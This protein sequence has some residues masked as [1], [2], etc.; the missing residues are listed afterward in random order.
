MA[1]D[2]GSVIAK[3]KADLTEFKQGLNQ[4][5]DLGQT[6]ADKV[7]SGIDSMNG[8]IKN[9]TPT[10]LKAS[11]TLGVVGAAGTVMLKD[12]IDNANEAARTQ[13]Q[14][15][16][17]LKS[18]KGAAGLTADEVN[19]LASKYQSMTTIGDDAIRSG[20]NILLTFT[21]IKKDAFEP[22]TAALL[23]MATAMNGGATPSAEQ[24]KAQATQLGTALNDPVK[25]MAALSRNG[26]VFTDE[27]AALITKLQESGDLLG[28]QKI[29]L[30][31][32]AAEYGGSAAAQTLTFE[33][34][35]TQL[36][37]RF[38]DF[39]ETL[40]FAV[41]PAL[42]QLMAV[43]ERVMTW[44]ENLSPA[45]Q[46]LIAKGVLLGTAL[47]LIGAPLLLIVTMIPALI[48]GF[49]AIAG[50]IALLFSPITLVIAMFVA[51]G[52]IL[53]KY[54]D[55]FATFF[56]ILG[57]NIRAFLSFIVEL[58]TSDFMHIQTIVTTTFDF[59]TDFLSLF[60]DTVKMLFKLWFAV[61]TGDWKGAWDVIKN[62]AIGAFNVIQEWAGKFWEGLTFV[63]TQGAQLVSS[64]WSG[65][66]EG[67]KSIALTVWE[68]IKSAFKDGINWIIDK[69]N[70][71]IRSY[72]SVIS[73]VPGVGKKL[74]IPEIPRLAQ[75]GIVK[76][77]PGGIMAN[78]GEGRYDEA[79]VPLDGRTG[80][81]GTHFHFHDSIISSKE[82]A[83]EILDQAMRTIRPNL[84]I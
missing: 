9:M 50:G 61:F 8:S 11:A 49:T 73:K 58:W 63:F 5:K 79:V 4:A 47:A 52:I 80:M 20:Q 15:E 7:K 72:S 62:W 45:T 38:G 71:V 34:R 28:A 55:E 48:A 54:R 77:T 10:L 25:G 27:Q 24:L 32:L 42:E 64:A 2:A 74:T 84:G 23:D 19:N 83:Q 13:T 43:G 56:Q 21:G 46:G 29:I 81:L 35:L 37:N 41:I 18:T 30:N 78:I 6:M 14:L 36:N 3:I 17:V 26:V 31:E 67:V 60:M 40:G 57:D 76:A 65:M 44:F 69:L 68:G 75:G 1:F 22:A 82:A 53:Y 33:G 59:I 70:A 12:W 51:L 66:M 16:A 39:K